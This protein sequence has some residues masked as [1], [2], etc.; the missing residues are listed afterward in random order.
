MPARETREDPADYEIRV[1]GAPPA[2]F[3]DFYFYLLSWS[4]PAMLSC[5]VA[6]FLAA[7]ALFALLYM[8]VGGVDN[9][10]PGS[11]ADAY[12][13]SVQ[14]MGTIGYGTMA[15]RSLG[16]NLLMVSESVVS[17]L[18]TAL[19]TG[20]I[21]AKFSRPTARVLFGRHATVSLMNGKPTLSFRIGNERSN[22]IVDAAVRVTL[23]QTEHTAEGKTHYRMLDLPLVRNRIT[24]LTRSWMVFHE[25]DEKSPLYGEDAQSAEEKE[26]ELFIGVTGLDDA[27]MQTVHANY[28]YMHHNI[29]WNR[30][31]ADVLSESADHKI[32][33]LDL[34][35]FHE[36]DPEEPSS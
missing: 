26:M 6:T 10:R 2:R 22:R 16:A 29:A 34:T 14:T 18:V 5:I 30:R 4:W 35:K 17:L 20:L 31:M 33:T 3:R 36:L 24:S 12:F 27:W 9:A 7:N 28:R 25:I 21:F 11:F 19:S 8:A 15:P 13:F 32:V 23:S 1:V